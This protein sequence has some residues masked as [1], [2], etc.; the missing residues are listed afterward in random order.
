MIAR[1]QVPAL[2]LA[3]SSDSDAALSIDA[4]TGAV[5]LADDPD[6]EAPRAI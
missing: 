2:P 1:I 6:F 3:L 4:S 5:T